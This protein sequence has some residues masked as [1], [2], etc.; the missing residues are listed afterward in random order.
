MCSL[1]RAARLEHPLGPVDH[2]LVVA[3]EEVDHQSFDAPRFVERKSF[4]QVLAERLP[5][6]PQPDADAALAGVVDD[7]RAAR[8]S[9]RALRT[10]A[11]GAG[12]P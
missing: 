1:W 9:G 12:S 8:I 3:V 4:F 5:M 11:S 7:F 2:L 10:S 6:H